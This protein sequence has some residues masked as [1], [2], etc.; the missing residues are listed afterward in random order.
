MFAIVELLR[1]IAA[2]MIAP[3]FAHLAATVGGSVEAGTEIALWIG[4]A[5]AI[6][7]AVIGVALYALGG[8]RPQAPDLERF[9]D[10]DDPAWY[11]P[12]CWP[13]SGDVTAA[14]SPK[15]P[16]SAPRLRADATPGT[17]PS[18][19]AT[20]V[21]Q[22]LEQRLGL[23]ERVGRRTRLLGD[24]VDGLLVSSSAYAGCDAS[25]SAQRSASAVSASAGTTRFTRRIA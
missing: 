19:P 12:R 17:G 18:R 15:R 13:P 20:L 6:G 24:R 1:A 9:M 22:R 7:A 10:G 8:A 3:V 11:S 25:F 2:F 5:L 14:R 4:L 16:R 23:A 21:A